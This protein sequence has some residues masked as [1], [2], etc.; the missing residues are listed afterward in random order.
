MEVENCRGECGG[1]L[2]VD[3]TVGEIRY[4]LNEG[5]SE[6]FLQRGEPKMLAIFL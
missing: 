5:V 3:I 1:G 6:L 2:L 4:E